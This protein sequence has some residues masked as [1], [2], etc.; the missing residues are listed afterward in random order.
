MIEIPLKNG[1]QNARQKFT[2]TLGDYQLSMTLNY[3]SYLDIPMWSLSVFHDGYPIRLGTA[4]AVNGVIKMGKYGVLVLVG[5]EP[6][7][8][9]LGVDNTLIWA[10]E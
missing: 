2:V 4:L 10:V 9:N 1:A 3:L 5:N 7:L 6:T 8:D